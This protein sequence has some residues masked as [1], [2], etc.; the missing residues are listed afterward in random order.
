MLVGTFYDCRKVECVSAEFGCAWSTERLRSI[1]T[2]A[3]PSI[4][5]QQSSPFVP[6]TAKVEFARPSNLASAVSERC[7]NSRVGHNICRLIQGAHEP[8]AVTEFLAEPAN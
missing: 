2:L 3:V 7:F 4:D 8:S 1:W 6:S 5:W